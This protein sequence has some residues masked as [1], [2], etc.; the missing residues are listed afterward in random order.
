MQILSVHKKTRPGMSA[1]NIPSLSPLL[2]QRKQY[3][4]LWFLT[5]MGHPLYL[6]SCSNLLFLGLRQ[7]F[8]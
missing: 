5:W 1:D 7:H 4:G 6:S 3:C 2:L 8:T